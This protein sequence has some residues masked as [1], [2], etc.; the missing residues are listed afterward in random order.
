MATGAINT[1]VRACEF[2]GCGGVVESGCGRKAVLIMAICA[3]VPERSLMKIGVATQ[4]ILIQTE[5][6]PPGSFGSRSFDELGL[7]AT[8]A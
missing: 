7:M 6:S 1:F 5:K 2:E 8:R 4:A 3:G